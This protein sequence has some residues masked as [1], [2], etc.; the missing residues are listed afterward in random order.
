ME[1]LTGGL[2]ADR[3]ISQPGASTTV[4]GGVVAYT[5]EMK[6]KT[7]VPQ[8]LLREHG[9]VSAEVARAMA[10]AIKRETGADFGIATTGYA[11]PAGGNVEN[12]V[13]TYY[14]AI[15]GP[16]G[17]LERHRRAHSDRHGVRLAAVETA[18]TLLWE[19]LEL[20]LEL[21]E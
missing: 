18:L 6:I 7:G 4:L 12:P 5:D 3:F 9:A 1:S 13:G 14:V 21:E 17:L 16:G 15:D 11:G 2:V 20:P 19:C 8:T 10:R